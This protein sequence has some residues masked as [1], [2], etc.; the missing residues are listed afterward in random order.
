MRELHHKEKH[1][2]QILEGE[3]TPNNKPLIKNKKHLEVVKSYSKLRNKVDKVNNNTLDADLIA[4]MKLSEYLGTKSFK[5]ATRQDI[6]DFS[7]YLKEK[8]GLGESSIG[9]YLM[10]LKRFYKYVIEPE[11][12]ANGKSD[13]KDIRYPDSVRWITYNDNGNELPLDNIP[14]RKEISKLFN[15]CKDVRDQ[16]I[17]CG[18]LDGGLRKSELIGLKIR[19]V[20]FDNDLKKFY[21]ILPKKT[22]GQKT[23]QRYIQLFLIDSSTAYF[24]EYLNHHSFKNN[25]DAPFIYSMDCSVRHRPVN[26]K[27]LT[28]YGINEI[29]DR[30]VKD[31]GLKYHITPH[32]LRHISATWCCIKGFN[33][34][35]L[36]ERFGWS[37]R[38]KMPSRYVHLANTDMKNKIMEILGIK[39]EELDQ[40]DE[41]QSQ[42]CWNCQEENPFSHVYCWKCGV[43]IKRKQEDVLTAKEIGISMQKTMSQ[44]EIINNL[45]NKVVQLEKKLDE[46]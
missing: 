9:L 40:V 31:S 6:M 41:L 3:Y 33:E 20:K 14:T 4:I 5:Q 16:V 17:L 1:I 37:K 42:V 21:F 46:K 34:P 44:E 38:S 11:L 27:Y 15:A 7:D 43:E 8:Q 23:G 22:H 25:P 32:T 12:Y 30:I 36:R 10:K 13:Q 26:E 28:E 29:I 24:K 2:K 45:Y 39:K 19:N 35:M 18:L